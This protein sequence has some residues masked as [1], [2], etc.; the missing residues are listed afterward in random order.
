[1]TSL[2]GETVG[3][4]SGSDSPILEASTQVS[5]PASEA[6][7]SSAHPWSDTAL[8]EKYC[9]Q[10]RRLK[11]VDC[12]PGISGGVCAEFLTDKVL[13]IMQMQN[14]D[15][16]SN[17]ALTAAMEEVPG[18]GEKFAAESCRTQSINCAMIALNLNTEFDIAA[19]RLGM[20]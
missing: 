19:T 1:M 11:D 18:T 10:V 15:D 8:C 2:P 12:A 20:L 6:T 9:D 14:D 7:T 3:I 17:P 13:L 4:S 5:A 16:G